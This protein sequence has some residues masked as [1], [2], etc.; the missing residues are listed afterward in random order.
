ME[1][2]AEGESFKN[3]HGGEE[4]TT[5]IRGSGL[6]AP[7]LICTGKFSLPMTQYVTKFSRVGSVSNNY[8]VFEEY[9]AALAHRRTDDRSWI[10]FGG[11][12]PSSGSN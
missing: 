7:I 8:K 1:L 5:F 6:Q 9:V 11:S 2:N 12:N 4:I 3:W 10:R